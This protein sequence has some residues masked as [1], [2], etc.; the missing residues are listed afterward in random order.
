MSLVGAILLVLVSVI[1]I[2]LML[3]PIHVVE[4]VPVPRQGH[5]CTCISFA[6]LWRASDFLPRF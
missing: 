6:K 3:L 1:G 5:E 4:H 2:L